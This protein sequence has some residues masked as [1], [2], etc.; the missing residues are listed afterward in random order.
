MELIDRHR[1]IAG[2]MEVTL[3]V[4]PYMCLLNK[5]IS[6]EK[7]SKTRKINNIKLH[8]YSPLI[9]RR[10]TIERHCSYKAKTDGDVND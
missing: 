3:H 1:E 5:A 6:T 4:P 7:L 10:A 9:R 8:F 2:T